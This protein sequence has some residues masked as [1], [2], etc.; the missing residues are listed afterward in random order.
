MKGV[1][2]GSLSHRDEKSPS[3]GPWIPW[4][5]GIKLKEHS[6]AP[7]KAE[8]Y[9]IAKWQGSG[10]VGVWANVLNHIGFVCFFEL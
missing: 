8:G 4:Q 10:V 1:L 7:G 5:F 6:L 9:I 3:E 2:K